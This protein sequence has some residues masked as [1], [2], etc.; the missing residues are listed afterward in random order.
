MK[1]VESEMDTEG[2]KKDSLAVETRRIAIHSTSRLVGTLDC[3]CPP[4]SPFFFNFISF[5]AV[6]PIRRGARSE[7]HVFASL[8]S[9][10][11]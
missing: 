10:F 4:P 5:L 8:P 7:T 9:F 2:N 3:A 1:E 11:F 6:V